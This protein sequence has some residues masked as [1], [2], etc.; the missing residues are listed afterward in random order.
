MGQI[1]EIGEYDVAVVGAGSAGCSAAIAAARAGSRVVL[2]SQQG[3]LGGVLVSGLPILGFFD[4]EGQRL[5]GGLAEEYLERLWAIPGGASEHAIGDPWCSSNVSVNGQ[6][7]KC[8]LAEMM[9]EAGVT[10]VFNALVDG[11]VTNESGRVCGIR[12]AGKGGESQIRA[13]QIVDASGDGDVAAMAGAPFEIGGTGGI[14]QAATLMFILD[15]IDRDTFHDY[16][17]NDPDEI[18]TPLSELDQPAYNVVGLWK[19]VAKAKQDGAWPV[20]HDRV[21]MDSLPTPSQFA[22]NLT[23]VDYPAALDTMGLSR[24]ELATQEQVIPL[25]KFFRSYVPGF[26]NS[27]LASVAGNVGIR[28][29]RHIIGSYVLTEDDLR[30]GARFSDVIAR[31]GYNIDLHQ[32]SK[33]GERFPGRHDSV[34]PYDIP[35]RILVPLDVEGVIVAGRCV[36]ATH[37]AAGSLRV[38]GQTIAMGQAAGVAAALAIES[39]VELRQVDIP[40]LQGRLR[41]QGAVLDPMPV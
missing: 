36:S 13:K 23:R 22:I 37:E 9:S 1:S 18:R 31:G 34:L 2:I 29:S 14:I 11:V 17:R 6:L 15:G 21:L 12:L 8:V 28:E 5:V 4:R 20:P 30:S 33:T 25:L 39:S 16:I 19:L 26:E 27:Y 10:V 38:M 41:D 32:P 3:F 7:L 35:Y 40:T 24:I